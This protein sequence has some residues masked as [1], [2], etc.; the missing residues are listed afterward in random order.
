[1]TCAAGRLLAQRCGQRAP[2]ALRRLCREAAH[3]L[4]EDLPLR[5][6]EHGELRVSVAGPEN[7]GQ[8][9]RD[10]VRTEVSPVLPR[11]GPQSRQQD[12]QV[13]GLHGRLAE[14]AVQ[15]LWR[16]ALAHVPCQHIGVLLHGAEVPQELPGIPRAGRWQAGRGQG[17][18]RPRPA[19]PRGSFRGSLCSFGCRLRRRLCFFNTTACGGGRRSGGSAAGGWVPVSG[20]G[21]CW[22]PRLRPC[23]AP[24]W[25]MRCG[26][27]HACS[28]FCGSPQVQKLQDPLPQ[29]GGLPDACRLGHLL[30]D[31]VRV[32]QSGLQAADLHK[33]ERPAVPRLAVLAVERYR[34][35]AVLHCL[36]PPAQPYVS[37]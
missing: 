3:Q 10:D 25:T 32:L 20:A 11:V 35:G 12:R 30:Q 9:V 13:I 29:L 18:H 6:T 2:Q 34:C 4:A 33:R 7:L 36:F 16:H 15:Q 14:E 31:L 5:G 22:W 23:A 27:L 37:E 21:R 28:C 8:V 17:P 24:A 26:R 19:G 1:M